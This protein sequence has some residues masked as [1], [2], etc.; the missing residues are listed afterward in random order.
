MHFAASMSLLPLDT[1]ERIELAA[2]WLSARENYKWLDFGNGI[3]QV[4]PVT[5]RIMTQRNLHVFRLYTA[6]GNDE[7][8]GIVGLSNV[9]RTFKTASVWAVLGRKRYGG[10]TAMACSQLLAYGFKELGLRSISA[11]TVEINT[12]A[13]RTLERL[14]FRYIGRQ[15]QCHEIDGRCVRSPALRSPG[16]RAPGNLNPFVQA[17]EDFFRARYGREALYLPSGRAALFLAFREWLAPGDRVLMSPVND[18]VVFFV[19][20]AAGL[21]PVLGPIDPRTGNLDP[22]AIADSTWTTLRGILTTNLYGIPDRM[23]LLA[24]R[25]RRHDLVLVEDAAHAIDSRCDGRRIGEFGAAAAYSLS[26]HLGVTGGV[27][28]FADVGRRPSLERWAAREF[29]HR[30]LP[31]VIAQRARSVFKGERW[32]LALRDR[33]VPRPRE[34]TGHRMAYDAGTVRRAQQQGGGFD[35]FDRWVRVDNRAY[36]TWPERATQ[37]AAL[38]GLREFEENRHRRLAG[39]R[40]LLE[41]GLTPVGLSVPADVA[42]FRVPLFVRGREA[43]RAQMAKRGLALDYIYD[44]PLDVYAPA[45]TERLASG[46]AA[47][48]WSSDV[49]PVDPALADRFLAALAESP[50]LIQPSLDA[51]QYSA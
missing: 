14:H 28:T 47:G 13:Q 10:T 50:G 37:R 40:K 38:R 43:V 27:L 18:D 35:R 21:V 45:L 16:V 23:D 3:Q 15:R 6:N 2:E 31:E 8:A 36:R 46:G 19:V 48:H 51:L 30:S 33:L 24:E 20:L 17:I 44:P 26:K 5:L 1:P 12:A 39:G 4:S 42:L 7:P 41:L 22:T 34:R 32:I 25:C 9:D 29:R 49:L 11:W